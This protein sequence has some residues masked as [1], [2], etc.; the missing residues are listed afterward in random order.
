MA[1]AVSDIATAVTIAF[2]GPIFG[3]DVT[4]RSDPVSFIWIAPVAL[5][6]NLLVRWVKLLAYWLCLD[7]FTHILAHSSWLLVLKTRVSWYTEVYGG[8]GGCPEGG[9]SGSRS[10][11]RHFPRLW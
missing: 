2:S 5:A 4:T 3:M 7:P 10:S 6:V 11:H 8:R 9:F 1:G